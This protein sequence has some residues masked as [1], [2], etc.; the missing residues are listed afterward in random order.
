MSGP[1]VG[2][3]NAV[4]RRDEI[5]IGTALIGRSSATAV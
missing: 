3:G 2:I 5:S 4:G 1:V